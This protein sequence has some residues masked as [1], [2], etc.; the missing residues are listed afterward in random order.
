MPRF[1]VEPSENVLAEQGQTLTLDC[2]AAGEPKPEVTWH[3]E[4]VKQPITARH[5][6]RLAVLANNSLR[7]FQF[8]V[9]VSNN[10]EN[11]QSY[12]HTDPRRVRLVC[13]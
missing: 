10:W 2:T 6:Q 3:R 5:D 11:V 13:T 4:T 7:C 9:P 8:F 1:E 12:R